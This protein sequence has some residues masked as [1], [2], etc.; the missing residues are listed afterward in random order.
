MAAELEA[1]CI[2]SE[3]TIRDAM[4]ALNRNLAGIVLVVDDGRHLLGTVT[5]GDIR[6]A[7]LGGATFETRCSTFMTTT[8]TTVTPQ[9]PQSEVLELSR[10]R[11]IRQ[12]P[13]LD[14][15]GVLVQVHFPQDVDPA[16]AGEPEPRRR[17]AHPSADLRKHCAVVMAGGL[18]SRLGD[19][20]QSTPKPLIPVGGKPILEHIVEHLRDSGLH[21]IYISTRY[22]A[23]L[24]EAH[25]ADGAD[26]GVEIE[27]IREEK[28]LGTAGGLKY[29]EGKIEEPFLVMNGDL[30]TDFDAAGMFRF[31]EENEAALTVAVRHYGFE[32]P[33]G[34]VEVEGLRVA[35]LSEKPN[36]DFFVNAGI[37]IVDPTLL[38][39]I[40][41]GEYYDIT[42]LIDVAVAEGHPVV[43][44]PIV[45]QWIDV[46]RPVDLARAESLLSGEEPR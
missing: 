37:Y 17:S 38:K 26:W 46:G 39:F 30:L 7:L 43:S 41:R 14:A 40:P 29:L 3:A 35:K 23:E 42:T 21:D 19:L 5:D 27:Y 4:E 25:F 6:R 10:A 33:Y 2:G 9:T 36:F 32:V 15:D 12:V 8:P 18:G 16:T 20:T 44:F 31:H 28:R 13:V 22:L 11:R 34:V 45:E 1:L 24:I